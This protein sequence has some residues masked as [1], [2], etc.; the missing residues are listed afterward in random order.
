MCIPSKRK[1]VKVKALN[2]IT[3]MNETKAFVKH[4]SCGCKCKFDSATC[5][6][7]QQ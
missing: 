1:D 4:V 2:T 3:R 5:N 7:N 6:S